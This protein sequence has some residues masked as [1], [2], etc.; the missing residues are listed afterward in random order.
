VTLECPKAVA[1]EGWMEIDSITDIQQIADQ[2]NRNRDEIH[3][4][5]KR[6]AILEHSGSSFSAIAARMPMAEFSAQ[7]EQVV[8]VTQDMFGDPETQVEHD[9][10]DPETPYVVLTVNVVGNLTDLVSRRIEWHKRI[11]PLTPGSHGT[12]RLSMIPVE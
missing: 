3:A 9:P 12:F 8:Q 10:E 7:L 4:L 1:G 6:I 5:E 11:R 2:L